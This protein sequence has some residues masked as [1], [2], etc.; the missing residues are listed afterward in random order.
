MRKPLWVATPTLTTPVRSPSTSTAVS[1]SGSGNNIYFGF[2]SYTVCF[3]SS[4]VPPRRGC[5]DA[6]GPKGPARS[7]APSARML[8]GMVN[9]SY[10]ITITLQAAVD[11]VASPAP[12]VKGA[13]NSGDDRA[14]RSRFICG[15]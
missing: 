3:R 6:F 15:G 7:L 1:A 5:T 8:I 10:D 12:I 13:S 9:M 11:A 4:A 2:T 14:S